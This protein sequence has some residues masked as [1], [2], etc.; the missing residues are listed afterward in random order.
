MKLKCNELHFDKKYRTIENNIEKLIVKMYATKS[1]FPDNFYAFRNIKKLNLIVNSQRWEP[2]NSSYLPSLEYLRYK[3]IKTYHKDEE[4][5]FTI[6][7]IHL[8]QHPSP[9]FYGISVNVASEKAVLN[10]NHLLG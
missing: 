6:P 10:D 7:N 4:F 5:H 8:V 9:K 3:F 1:H 2:I